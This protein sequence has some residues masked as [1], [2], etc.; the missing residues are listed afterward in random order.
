[1]AD[2]PSLRVVIDGALRD[3]ALSHAACMALWSLRRQL[4]ELHQAFRDVGDVPEPVRAA[5]RRVEAVLL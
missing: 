5:M 4:V 1:M 3:P 2:V